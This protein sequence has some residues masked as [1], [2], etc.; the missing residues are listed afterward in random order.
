MSQAPTAPPPPL[1][2]NQL[3]LATLALSLATFMNVLDT[4]IANVSIPT[5]AGDVG[6]SPSQG[7]WVITLVCRR[8]RHRGAA[9]RLAHPT[10]W[11]RT[12]VHDL[13][14]AIRTSLARLRLVK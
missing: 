1:Q 8:Q 7:T 5:I 9:Y 13:G 14:A 12:P 2:G 3:L 10:L 4:S 11:R 6:V